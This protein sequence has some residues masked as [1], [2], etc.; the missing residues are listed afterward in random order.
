[1]SLNLFALVF[2]VDDPFEPEDLVRLREEVQ[3]ESDDNTMIVI[4]PA[5]ADRHGIDLDPSGMPSASSLEAW[6]RKNNP[7]LFE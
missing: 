2:G 1:M 7:H 6:H 5:L 4:D 3:E